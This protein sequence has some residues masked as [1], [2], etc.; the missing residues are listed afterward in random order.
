MC[1]LACKA[2]QQ[3]KEDGRLGMHAAR[4]TYTYTMGN[5]L[6]IMVMLGTQPEDTIKCHR[7]VHMEEQTR[8]EHWGLER[9]T[10]RRRTLSSTPKSCDPGK[11]K[12]RDDTMYMASAQSR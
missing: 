9:E 11:Q 8:C 12:H 3:N 6:A 5:N 4:R 2:N 10:G 7:Q 1:V